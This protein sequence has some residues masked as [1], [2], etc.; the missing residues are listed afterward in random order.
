MLAWEASDPG[1]TTGPENSV[2]IPC[3]LVPALRGRMTMSY[4]QFQVQSGAG[5]L[6]APIQQRSS[7][8][9]EA[10]GQLDLQAA[11]ILWL[12]GNPV[13]IVEDGGAVG[14]YEGIPMRS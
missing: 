6:K 12:Y 2:R 14:Q 5:Y 7:L 11:T 4:H 1:P 10:T 13:G 8:F 3:R 9:E